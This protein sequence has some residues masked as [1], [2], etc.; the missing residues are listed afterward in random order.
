[1]VGCVARNPI[2]P[3][4]RLLVRLRKF[5]FLQNAV[6]GSTQRLRNEIS[7][8]LIPAMISVSILDFLFCKLSP[9]VTSLAEKEFTLAQFPA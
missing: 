4:S 3:L 8:Q 5:A 2:G 9:S 6:T 7:S 1:M